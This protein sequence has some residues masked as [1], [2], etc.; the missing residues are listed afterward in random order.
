MHNKLSQRDEPR[1]DINNNN[2]VNV[3]YYVLQNARVE[4]VNALMATCITKIKNNVTVSHTVTSYIQL[5][6]ILC[7]CLCCQERKIFILAH[8]I[9]NYSSVS[10][11]W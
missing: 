7:L 11:Q 6:V 10:D 9:I 3:C 5:S 8:L 4:T 1:N 2:M